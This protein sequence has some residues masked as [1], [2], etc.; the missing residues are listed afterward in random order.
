V[1]HRL[2]MKL[3][4]FILLLIFYFPAFSQDE[5][6]TKDSK[7]LK[8]RIV[9]EE[10]KQVIFYEIDDPEKSIQQLEK[11]EIKKI[12]YD[13][14]LSGMNEIVITDDS[15]A[16]EDLFSHIVSYLIDTGYELNTFD[17]EHSTVSVLTSAYF[18]LSVEI[19]G[20]KAFFSGFIPEVKDPSIPSQSE[21]N[22]IRL[23]PR[24]EKASREVKYPGEQKIDAL[25]RGFKEMDQICRKYLMKNKG[26]LEYL[27]E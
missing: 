18:R 10:K 16:G 22:V 8:V 6:I 9:S 20:N 4:I 1:S 25:D 2:V 12:R 11:K 23:V 7:T 27:K 17:M 21:R 13:T 3:L 15:L 5:I 19:D 26:S 14:P 24:D